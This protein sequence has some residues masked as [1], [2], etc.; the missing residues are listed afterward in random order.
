MV[1]VILNNIY[2]VPYAVWLVRMV[3]PRRAL[4]TPRQL[5]GG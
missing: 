3:L 2:C 4:Y 1:Y 5:E